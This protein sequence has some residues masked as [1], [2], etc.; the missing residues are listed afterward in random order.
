MQVSGFRIYFLEP[1][2]FFSKILSEFRKKIVALQPVSGKMDSRMRYF[3]EQK[4]IEPNSYRTE[5][6]PDDLSINPTSWRLTPRGEDALA[7][8]EYRAKQESKNDSENKRERIFQVLLVFLG[9]IIGLLIERISG[10]TA[11]ISSFF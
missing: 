1:G 2:Y 6:S 11:W 7:E 9:A 5:G 3:R 4:Y 10:I 8:F